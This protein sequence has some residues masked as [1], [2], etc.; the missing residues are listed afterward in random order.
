MTTKI[1]IDTDPGQD[2]A[3]T[4]LLALASP[5][6]EL[7]GVTTV[8]GNVGV[9]Q[10]TENAIKALDLAG[11]PDVPVHAGAER[12]LLRERVDATHVHGRTGFEGA[13]LPPPRRAPSPG[14]AVDFIIRTVMENE[15]G[16]VT[17]CAIGPLTNI[18]LAL[19]REP[20]L[21]TRLRRIVTMSGAFAE[22]GNITPSAEFNVYVDPHAADMVLRSG[23]ELVMAPLDLT[24]S[25]HTSAA[26]L[27]RFEAIGNRVGR[28]VA[29]WLRFEKRFEATKY[30]TDGG[31]LH[32]PNTVLW[33]LR[34][35]LYRGKLVNVRVETAS[36]LTMGMT[37]VD[38]WGVTDL[39]TNVQFLREGDADAL[40]DVIVELLAR[41]KDDGNGGTVA[42]AFL[43][44]RDS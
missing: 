11:R 14:H 8:A 21:R 24:H 22:V 12:A 25:L 37:V 26:R 20:A 1:I 27:A 29:G 17:I 39:P 34:P 33:L 6:I 42:P 40:Y 38:W 30:G 13:D 43:Q 5:E 7:L 2:D 41:F 3:L 36:E 18:A 9:A 19:A 23:V 15:P 32:D 31:P 35:D 16:E 10:A 4:I 44:A 28:V